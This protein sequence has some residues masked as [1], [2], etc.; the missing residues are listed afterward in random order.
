M[1]EIADPVA[2]RERTIKSLVMPVGLANPLWLAFSAAASAGACW[3]LMTRWTKP[4]NAEAVLEGL[5]APAKTAAAKA[6]AVA[7]AEKTPETTPVLLEVAA[8]TATS[9]IEAAAA[10]VEAALEAVQE[11]VE[12][13]QE[14]VEEEAALLDEALAEAAPAFEGVDKDEA[15]VVDDL[16]RLV[17]VGPRTAAA[18]AE[19]G[20]V[21]FADLA[22]WSEDQMAAFD[23]ELSLKGRSVRDAWLAQA[24]RLAAEG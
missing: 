20:V 1:T 23:Q 5:A 17:G 19:R 15:Q 16:T 21:R 4:F 13:V 7:P 8:Q 12:D 24:R 9:L 6:S 10:P 22:S 18:L 14:A 11:R 3:W 2:I